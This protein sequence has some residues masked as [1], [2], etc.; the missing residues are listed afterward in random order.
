MKDKFIFINPHPR[1]MWM[2][3]ISTFF[4]TTGFASIVNAFVPFATDTLLLNT[5]E[6][7]SISVVAFLFLFN[8]AALAG[9]ILGYY[10]NHRRSVIAGGLFATIGLALI[11]IHNLSIIG[12]SAYS[13][14]VGLIIPNLYTILSQLY[15]STNPKRLSAFMIFYLA[16]NI[17]Y[18]FNTAL[19]DILPKYIGFGHFFLLSSLFT[20]IGTYIFLFSE[21]DFRI[22]PGIELN[23]NANKHSYYS[24]FFLLIV[25]TFIARYLLHE[26]LYTA[27]LMVLLSFLS[28]CFIL[29]LARKEQFGSEKPRIY[30]LIFIL[31]VC[32]IF[33]LANRISLIVFSQYPTLLLQGKLFNIN[34]MP[35]NILYAINVLVVALIGIYLSILWHRRKKQTGVRTILKICTISLTFAGFAFLLFW[36]CISLLK[37]NIEIRSII[38][39]IA[40]IFISVSEIILAPIYFATAG[41]F[42][43]RK[44]ESII[45]GIQ[46]LYIGLMGCIAVAVTQQSLQFNE[47]IKSHPSFITLPNLYLLM[48]ILILV[49]ALVT[50]A[51]NNLFK[52]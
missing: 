33:W 17:G 11:S 1:G 14:G 44:Y 45:I 15:A 20:L 5:H 27:T 28:L 9:G 26:W 13:I 19:A 29:N 18:F 34:N 4:F 21:Q 22:K 50:F 37:I 23:E 41:K 47:L 6:A 24:L 31:L 8:F 52:N 12:V 46:Q 2:I 3:A 42:A 35:E 43:P 40:A 10:Y 39:I 25:L 16:S 51:S 36:A 38:L 30:V 49:T 48:C 32:S 7:Q